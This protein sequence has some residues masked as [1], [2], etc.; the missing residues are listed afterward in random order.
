MGLDLTRPATRAGLATLF[1]GMLLGTIVLGIGGR[2]SMRLV[3]EAT[4]GSSGF[5]LGG[6]LTVVFLGLASGA[7]GG[8]FLLIARTVFRRWP[9]LPTL[10]YWCLLLGIT[11]RG[12]RPV[13]AQRLLYFL[14]VVGLF[15]ILLQWRTW[16]YRQPVPAR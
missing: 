1:W 10:V 8:A 16:R 12:L 14:P 3:A 15:G 7:L 9:P 13:D 2:I 4:S 11:L 5:T 6:S